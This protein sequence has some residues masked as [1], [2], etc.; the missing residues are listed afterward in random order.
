VL[1]T[2][3]GGGYRHTRDPRN[4]TTRFARTSP[5]CATAK[6]DPLLF[7]DMALSIRSNATASDYR[8]DDSGTI[9]GERDSNSIPG[10]SAPAL[11]SGVSAY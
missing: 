7:A 5:H 9:D 1:Y 2:G 6:R 3:D 11:Q 10:Y 4:S 8:M